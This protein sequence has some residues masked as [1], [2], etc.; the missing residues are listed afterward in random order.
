MRQLAN[1]DRASAE[2]LDC[3]R[4]RLKIY[5]HDGMRIL[6]VLRK[7]L[8]LC[9]LAFLQWLSCACEGKSDY[10]LS[11]RNPAYLW[12][13]RVTDYRLV[14]ASKSIVPSYWFWKR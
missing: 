2:S 11:D 3:A 5:P 10:K 8:S 4:P 14:A 12:L 9:L 6:T 1:F 13:Y 7:R